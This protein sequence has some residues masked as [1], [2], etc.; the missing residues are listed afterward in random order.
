MVVIIRVAQT[1]GVTYNSQANSFPGGA[2]ASSNSTSG[3]YVTYTY[4]L[5]SGQTIPA[6]YSNG[7]VYAQWGATGSVRSTSGDLWSV[8]STSGGV[9]STINGTF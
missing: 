6:N 2:L 8:T 3:G 7:E 9:T 4:T 1:T 5:N